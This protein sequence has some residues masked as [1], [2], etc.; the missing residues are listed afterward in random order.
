[1]YVLVC[2]ITQVPNTFLL[3]KDPIIFKYRVCSQTPKMVSDTCVLRNE[4]C[5]DRV[6]HP[7][8]NMHLTIIVP[9]RNPGRVV[10]YQ[11]C[12]LD[13]VQY[14]T[15]QNSRIVLPSLVARW[16]LLECSLYARGGIALLGHESINFPCP[17]MTHFLILFIYFLFFLRSPFR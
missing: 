4:H 11:E 5:R 12:A 3:T 8:R 17:I 16:S 6:R 1:M 7:L 10:A 9:V 14:I 2:C 15:M 13:P